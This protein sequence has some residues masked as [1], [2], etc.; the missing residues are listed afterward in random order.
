MSE[1]A[2]LP[3]ILGSDE[4]AYGTVRLFREAHGL[5]P[6]LLCTRRLVPTMD[7]DLFDIR[8]IP[9]FDREDV[10]PGALRAVLEEKKKE[11]G[12]LIVVACSDYYAGMMSRFAP[13]FGDLVA[14]RFISPELLETLDTKDKFYAL[15]EKHG[16]DYP[17]TVVA[18]PGERE[19]AVEKMDFTFPIVVK[20]ENS[21]AYEYLHCS[22]E[23]KKKVFFFDT[24]E[25]YLKVIRAMNGSD[26]RGKL[27]IQE[28]IPGGD[29]A[30]RVMNCYSGNDGKVRVMC[31]G[32]PVLEEY[33]PKTLGNYA[34]IITRSDGEIYGRLR[35]FLEEIGYVG[36]SNFDMK[37]DRRTGKYMMFEINPRPGRSSFFVRA[38]GINMMKALVDDAVNGTVPEGV[39]TADKKALWTAVPK[40]VLMKYVKD[41]VLREEIGTLWKQKEV[42][43]TL[44]NPEEKSLK[45][46]LR[47]LKYYLTYFKAYRQYYFDKEKRSEQS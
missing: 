11:Y 17:K 34:A 26:Y 7:S 43:R 42:Q 22:F 37:Y 33:S 5:R 19:S 15:C 3:V 13:A 46:R 29:D 4:N 45:R 41:P 39:L 20:P 27:I 23:G 35:A 24:K 6:L 38:A 16:L 8:C 25:E 36:Y 14:N 30:M 2:F 12:K 32:Q 31:L 10:F 28:F 40:G 9:D 1:N 47:V 21:N 44:F 18:E